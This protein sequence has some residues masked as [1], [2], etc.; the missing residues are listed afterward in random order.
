MRVMIKKALRSIQSSIPGSRELKNQLY[1]QVCKRLRVP[2]ESDFRYLAALPRRAD[3][4]FLDVGANWGQ[5][6][7]SM[8]LARARTPIVAF[9]PVPSMFTGIRQRLGRDPWLTLHNVGLG[10]AKATSTFYTPIYN[11]FIYDGLTSGDRESAAEWLNPATVYLFNPKKLEIMEQV[12]TVRTLDSFGLAPSFL[13][14]D[15]QGMEDAVIAGGAETIARHEPVILLERD[16][17][18][19]PAARRLRQLG[20]MEAVPQDGGFVAGTR[21]SMNAF[22]MTERTLHAIAAAN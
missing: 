2:H 4:L 21:A 19:G 5:S 8:R 22:W 18:D 13:K 9:E 14:I 7:M 11:G 20:Y 1:D 17:D 3:D 6:I 16:A 15:V 10:A 12:C